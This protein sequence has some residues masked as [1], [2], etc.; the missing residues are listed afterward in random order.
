[1]EKEQLKRK[2]IALRWDVE[3]VADKSVRSRMFKELRSYEEE[4]KDIERT[5]LEV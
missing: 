5:P 2:I 1:M 4:L 3:H